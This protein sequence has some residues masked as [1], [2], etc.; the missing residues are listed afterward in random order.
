MKKLSIGLLAAALS[1]PFA[2][3]AAQ[4]P[5]TTQT[6]PSK[7]TKKQTKTRKTH[8][9]KASTQSKTTKTPASK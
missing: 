5:A 7:T 9:K 6:A 4:T 8:H 2:L 3:A 1:L